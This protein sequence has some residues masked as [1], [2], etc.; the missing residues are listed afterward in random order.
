MAGQT[1]VRPSSNPV[2]IFTCIWWLPTCEFSTVGPRLEL[3]WTAAWLEVCFSPFWGK[4]V[5]KRWGKNAAVA[6]GKTGIDVENSRRKTSSVAFWDLSEVWSREHPTIWFCGSE[7]AFHNPT[8]KRRRSCVKQWGKPN[9]K[10][11]PTRV[12]D[13]VPS[14]HLT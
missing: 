7:G 9:N 4:W 1:L 3:F 11:S 13:W 2:R 14:G 10:Q 6:L 5:V 8:A 12:Y